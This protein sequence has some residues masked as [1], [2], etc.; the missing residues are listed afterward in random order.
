MTW[1]GR[2]RPCSAPDGT[3]SAVTTPIVPSYFPPFRFESQCDPIP[4]A[5]SARLR[6]TSVPRRSSVTVKPSSCSAA[7]KWSSVRRRGVGVAADRLAAGGEIRAGERLDLALDPGGAPLAIDSR[8]HRSDLQHRAQPVARGTSGSSARRRSTP[9]MPQCVRPSSVRSVG[10][11]ATPSASASRR[12][13]RSRSM[14]AV[15]RCGD[16]R[17]GVEPCDPGRAP[18]LRVGRDVEPFAEER[19]VE[20]VPNSRAGFFVVRPEAGSHR[21]RRARLEARQVDLDP[22]RKRAAVRSATSPCGGGRRGPRAAASGRGGA[23]GEPLDLEAPGVLG[24]LDDAGL[25][26][27]VRADDVEVEPIRSTRQVCGRDER[28]RGRYVRRVDDEWPPRETRYRPP[29]GT[30]SAC[31]AGQYLVVTSRLADVFGLAGDQESSFAGCT[32]SALPATARRSGSRSRAPSAREA[33]PARP[34]PGRRAARDLV[35][36]D[37][38]SAGGEL[39]EP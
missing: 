34:V 6:A 5:A 24:R 2:S 7:V 28:A 26:V 25:H 14:L 21:K 17:D 10:T 9:P 31:R 19:L 30:L 33:P 39:A 16:R 23:R 8:D 11:P 22:R 3:S 20:R 36:R 18:D 29:S 15:V 35:A 27:R 32:T 12:I 13:E 37:V 38:E 4:N 1:S